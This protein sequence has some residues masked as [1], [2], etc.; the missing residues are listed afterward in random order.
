MIDQKKHMVHRPIRFKVTSSDTVDQI[1]RKAKVLKDAEGF[2]GYSIPLI[3]Q[4]R[5]GSAAKSWLVNSRT[6]EQLIRTNI[7]SFERVKFSCRVR[8][9][10][11]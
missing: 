6:R 7:T 9:Q 11:V 4:S 1:L 3:D 8:D 10:D 2:K 5:R